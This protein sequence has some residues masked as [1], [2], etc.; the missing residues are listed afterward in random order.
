MTSHGFFFVCFVACL[1]LPPPSPVPSLQSSNGPARRDEAGLAH[2]HTQKKQVRG[3]RQQRAK[4]KD[5][6]EVGVEGKRKGKF[7]GCESQTSMM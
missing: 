5:R 4:N 1:F 2:E 6:V 3:A 7:E